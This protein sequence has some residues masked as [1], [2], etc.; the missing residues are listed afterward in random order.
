LRTKI[1][2]VET[3]TSFI[4]GAFISGE[5]AH[6]IPV[7]SPENGRT[8]MQLA[9]ADSGMVADAISAAR[10]AFPAWQSLSP[11][12]RAA[13]LRKIAQAIEAHMETLVKLESKDN[14][15][16]LWLTRR[17][18]IP[19][20]AANFNFFASAIEQW[21]DS[22]Y[23][24]DAKTL[25]YTRREPLGV[26]ACIS[27]W[28]LP[29]YLFTWK[30]APALAAGNTVVAKPSEITPAT[31]WYLG[32][33]LQEIDFPAGVLNIVQGRGSVTGASLTTHPD[34]KAISFTGGT[35]TGRTIA[36][37]AAGNF[38]K[39]SLEL[40]GKNPN[41]I[42]ADSDI[43]AA[44]ASAVRSSFTNQG[45]ICLCGSRIMVEESIYSEFRAK[46][47]AAVEGLRI[48]PPTQEGVFMS[49]VVSAD[50]LSK[51][52]S[53]VELAQAEGGTVMCGGKRL[54]FEGEFSE[55]YYFAPTVIEGLSM[56]ARCNQ[57]E[58]F[59][60]VV[61]LQPFANEADGIRMA[62]DSVYGLAG[63]VWTGD[64][65]RAHR[66]AGMLNCGI[67]WINCWMVRDLRT[68]FGG[69]RSSGMGREG[70]EEALRFFTEA[71]N[72]CIQY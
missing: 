61:T 15:K 21:S 18:D 10:N 63:Q 19:R 8:F 46:F 24:S 51:I 23:H 27:P 4:N 54:T 39:V 48:G 29:L 6:L 62:N 68:P 52:E 45:Q 66:I 42:F 57:E 47:V 60:P 34:V 14:G 40:G 53:Y 35:A 36:E 2:F 20:A 55:G 43:D 72:V 38:K 33:I 26:V 67:V 3:I 13:W 30:I 22:A 32:K 49:A 58:I 11:E 28:N 5:S 7:V 41:L 1:L 17:V 64:V 56:G 44:V 69:M 50:H 16:P 12:R 31:A 65:S 70:G 71:K 59:G 37:S 9:E 25:N